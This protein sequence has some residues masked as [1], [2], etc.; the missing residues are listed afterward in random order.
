M[1]V[2]RQGKLVYQK[3]YKHNYD[4]IYGEDAEK[5]SGLNQLDPGGPYNYYNDW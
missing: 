1:I 3:S 2:T 4:K 5:K